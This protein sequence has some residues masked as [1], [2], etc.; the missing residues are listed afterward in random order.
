MP[1]LRITSQQ[2]H[3]KIYFLAITV[4]IIVC[5]LILLIIVQS[6]SYAMNC[7]YS[8]G[9]DTFESFG[10]CRFQIVWSSSTSKSLADLEKDQNI[11]WVENI[12]KYREKDSFLY[13][14]G[15]YR[16]DGKTL[17]NYLILNT[18][19]STVQYYR[20]IE[21]I[22]GAEKQFFQYD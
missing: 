10:N 21:D 3:S 8:E 11:G 16:K 2:A 7:K 19:T 22:P 15:D 6:I 12:Q 18:K 1:S 13:V 9:I 20:D 17:G 5:A 14:T 4:L